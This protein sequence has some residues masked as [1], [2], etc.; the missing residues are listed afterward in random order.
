MLPNTERTEHTQRINT[1]NMD[2]EE[3]NNEPAEKIELENILR[4]PSV[5]GQPF[6]WQTLR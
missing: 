4:N 3:D 2:I 5:V 6:R 1:S